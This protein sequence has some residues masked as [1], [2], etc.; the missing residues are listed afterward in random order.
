GQRDP[1]VEYK[2][3]GLRLFN[4]LKNSINHNIL[5]RV[6]HIGFGGLS[7]DEKRAREAQKK[8]Q[9]ISGAI[10]KTINTSAAGAGTTQ[11]KIGRNEMV[12]ITNGKETKS[13]KYKKAEPLLETREWKL[14]E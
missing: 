10:S 12:E 2:K 6:P 4:D 7:E 5:E 3:E 13:I 14:V 9:I 8:A 1:L 11:Q